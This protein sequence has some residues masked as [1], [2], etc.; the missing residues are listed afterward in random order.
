MI[1]WRLDTTT[2][3]QWRRRTKTFAYTD[4][5]PTTN[6]LQLR[7]QHYTQQ[8]HQTLHNNNKQTNKQTTTTTNKQTTPTT[9]KQQQQTDLPHAHSFIVGATGDVL[10]A[11]V[12]RYRAHT[13]AMTRHRHCIKLHN[14]NNNNNIINN[15]N[16]N[17]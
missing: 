2:H 3:T 7:K 4:Q 9:N 6:E 10:A 11:G 8:Q 1:D 5:S 14:N 16:N 15:Y 17:K 13:F 12:H